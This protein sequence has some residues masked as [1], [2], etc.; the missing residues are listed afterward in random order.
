MTLSASFVAKLLCSFACFSQITL[1]Q[2]TAIPANTETFIFQT[3]RRSET[4]S[5]WQ[6][7]SNIA[8]QP[9]IPAGVFTAQTCYY[10]LSLWQEFQDANISCK[11]W[12]NT[13]S[14]MRV[15]GFTSG[16]FSQNDPSRAQIVTSTALLDSGSRIFTMVFFGCPVTL[17][18]GDGSDGNW[19]LTT[20]RA[21]ELTRFDSQPEPKKR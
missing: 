17:Q 5:A 9:V 18:T 8:W 13:S 10:S 4:F 7:T 11:A 15:L 19:D 2:N 1:P 14:C 21:V 16:T 6:I 12:P 20:Q 3:D